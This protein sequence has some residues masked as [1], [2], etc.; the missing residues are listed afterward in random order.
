MGKSSKSRPRTYSSLTPLSLLEMKYVSSSPSHE[1]VRMSD[2]VV[3]LRGPAGLRRLSTQ[4]VAL[5]AAL[6]TGKAMKRAQFLTGLGIV[7][8]LAIIAGVIAWRLTR[9]A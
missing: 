7:L 4:E 3:Y 1:L 5:L 8:S 2:G 6:Q 9:P